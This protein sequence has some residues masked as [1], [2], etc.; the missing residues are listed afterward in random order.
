VELSGGLPLALGGLGLALAKGGDA[1]GARALGERIRAMPPH[2]Y[3][4][5]TSLAFLHLGLGEI[6]E[7]FE[8]M[9]RAID[10]RDHMIMPIQTYPSFDAI[11]HDPRYAGLLRKMNLL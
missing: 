9:D 1:A 3:V 2:V 8:W 5:P 11:R 7:F 10:A 4:P 6:D